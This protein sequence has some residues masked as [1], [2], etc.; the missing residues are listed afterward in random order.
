MLVAMK[1][2]KKKKGLGLPLL[3]SQSKVQQQ[4]PVQQRTQRGK[5]M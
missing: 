3:S 1:M 2:A 5:R 4:V